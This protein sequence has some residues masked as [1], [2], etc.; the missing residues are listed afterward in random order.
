[1]AINTTEGRQKVKEALQL[2][3][4]CLTSIADERDV[5]KDIIKDL[6]D[7]FDLPKKII[8]KMGKVFHA[9]SFSEEK[10]SNE[11][12]EALYEEVVNMSPKSGGKSPNQA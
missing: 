10:A 2:M 7:E 8:R 12:F 5:I 3:S 1:M 4:R 9:Q 11:E 6:S